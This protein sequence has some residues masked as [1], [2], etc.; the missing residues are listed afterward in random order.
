MVPLVPPRRT[1][2]PPYKAVLTAVPKA[3]IGDLFRLPRSTTQKC[4]ELRMES[5]R[6]STGQD[7]HAKEHPTLTS[8]EGTD[9][10]CTYRLPHQQDVYRS[11]SSCQG[12][13]DAHQLPA[14][15]S[16]TDIRTYVGRGQVKHRQSPPASLED[17]QMSFFCYL[18]IEPYQDTCPGPNLRKIWT[19]S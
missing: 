4:M 12:A 9:K 1:V 2:S 16:C 11:G 8:C 17:F 19:N 18:L 7:H 3:G 14:H 13:S 15:R 5:N 10:H 6:T